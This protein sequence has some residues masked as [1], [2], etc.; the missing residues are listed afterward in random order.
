LYKSSNKADKALEYFLQANSLFEELYELAP[1][2]V[3][4]QNNLSYTSNILS[5][6]YEMLGE[7]NKA[8]EYQERV[9]SLAAEVR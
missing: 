1:E 4:F 7:G 5:Q 2:Y 8:R 6:I 3:E 9:D